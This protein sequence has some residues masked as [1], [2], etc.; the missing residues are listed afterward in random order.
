[1][2]WFFNRLHAHGS[3]D[4]I[5]LIR[6]DIK[7][8]YKQLMWGWVSPTYVIS[9][10]FYISSLAAF[11]YRARRD[12]VLWFDYYDKI[13]WN[14]PLFKKLSSPLGRNPGLILW[15][16]GSTG[17]PKA[18]LHDLT[19]LAEK[20]KDV[21]LKAKRILAFLGFDHIGGINTMFHTLATGGTLIV[22]D[23]RSAKSVCDA[24][25]RHKVQILPTTP[26]FLNMIILSG[27]WQNRDL[28]SLELITYGTEP[29]SEATLK[30]AVRI[31]PKVKF[32]Q[33][34]GLSEVGIL[35]TQSKENDSIWLKL[36]GE[37]YEVRVRDGML[38][39]KAKS[40]MLGYLN[41]PSPFTEDGWFITGDA[42]EQDG[43]WFRILG[44][45]SELINVGGEKV[46]PAELENFLQEIP[47]VL[48]VAVKGEPNALTGNL[49]KATFVIDTNETPA[50]FRMRMRIYCASKSL[51]SYKLPHRIELVD[52]HHNERFKKQR[53]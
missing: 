25:E 23:E 4:K 19:L 39:I 36:G 48:S 3:L 22:P 8:S 33:T 17:E 50:E 34:Y 15:S 44:R 18:A 10:K 32:K 53:V 51:P 14:H 13:D 16:S 9:K 1:M 49:I 35:A 41:A 21:K 6:D 38:E 12:E 24:I 29:M 28:S 11:L 20:H 30:A 26:T 31:F 43:D 37:G 46:Y 42:V 27:A 40:T 2:N 45:K 5:A 47:G 52:K 7:W